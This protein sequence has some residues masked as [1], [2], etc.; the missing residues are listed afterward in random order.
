MLDKIN[1]E[2]LSASTV[3]ASPI[4]EILL[5]DE[6][7]Y[8]LDVT[9]AIK[10]VDGEIG[11]YLALGKTEGQTTVYNKDFESSEVGNYTLPKNLYYESWCDG[12]ISDDMD[13]ISL[14][15]KQMLHNGDR[16]V[17]GKDYAAKFV[18]NTFYIICFCNS[19]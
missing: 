8:E 4:G 7:Y 14:K 12:V 15:V 13:S 19:F 1:R 10:A 3:S 6:G 9:D 17:A 11:F 5:S 18:N 16:T 2:D